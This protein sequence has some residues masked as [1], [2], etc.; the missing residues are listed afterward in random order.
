[1][2][3]NCTTTRHGGGGTIGTNKL[4]PIDVDAV[5]D[6][7]MITWKRGPVPVAQLLQDAKDERAGALHEWSVF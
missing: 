6:D 7:Q 1:M 3:S 5:R 2:Q 4:A